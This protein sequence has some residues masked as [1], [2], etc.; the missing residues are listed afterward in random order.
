M[1][2]STRGNSLP[3]RRPAA[4]LMTQ[5]EYVEH[6]SQYADQLGLTPLQIK[7]IASLMFSEQVP[8]YDMIIK[9][10]VNPHLILA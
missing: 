9:G 5:H 10:I 2:E 1:S 6:V 8:P 3:S 4:P 7:V